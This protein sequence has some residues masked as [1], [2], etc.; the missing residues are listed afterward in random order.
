MDETRLGS[1]LLESK[2]IQEADLEKCLEI[3]SL[4]GNHRPLGSIL[5]EQGLID[6]GTL[7]RLLELQE[8]RIEER[9]M[10]VGTDADVSVD[11]FLSTAVRAGARELVISEG[12]PVLARAGTEWRMLT[13]EPA[14]ADAAEGEAAPP[15]TQAGAPRE[16]GAVA[17][18]QGAQR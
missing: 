1:I 11:G 4:T 9:R 10:I 16:D 14:P 17:E 18:E 15:N 8:S 7:R 2:V 13:G 6:R 3:Q 12:R 5:V